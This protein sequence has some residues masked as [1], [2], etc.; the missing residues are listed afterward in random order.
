MNEWDSVL[1]A[2]DC[3]IEDRDVETMWVEYDENAQGL[4]TIVR[5]KDMQGQDVPALDIIKSKD[6]IDNEWQEAVIIEGV[7]G[8]DCHEVLADMNEGTCVQFY[9]GETIRALDSGE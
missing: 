1:Q 4:I 7:Y 5:H 9:I 6:M 3:M 8:R 2:L